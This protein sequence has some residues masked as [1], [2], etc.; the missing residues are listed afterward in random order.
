[1]KQGAFVLIVVAITL[2]IGIFIYYFVFGNTANFKDGVLLVHVPK[3]EK[4]RPKTI[5]VKVD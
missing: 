2:A 3:N 4:A 1:M 5:E